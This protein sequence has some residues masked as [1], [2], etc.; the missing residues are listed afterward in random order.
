[1]FATGSGPK[2]SEMELERREVV[3][4]RPQQNGRFRCDGIASEAEQRHARALECAAT[5]A[6]YPSADLWP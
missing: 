5:F 3:R 6:A 2:M 4:H 1:M